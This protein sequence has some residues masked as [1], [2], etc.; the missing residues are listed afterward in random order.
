MDGRGWDEVG[1]L[2]Q[3]VARKPIP[4]EVLVMRS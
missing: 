4:G 2:A 1:V 3:A